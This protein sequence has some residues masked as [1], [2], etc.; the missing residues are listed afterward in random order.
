MKQVVFLYGLAACLLVC[1]SV[2]AQDRLVGGDDGQAFIDD[3]LDWE[4]FAGRPA[5][6]V[7]RCYCSFDCTS[8]DTECQEAEGDDLDLP[9]Q[10]SGSENGKP[11]VNPPGIVEIWRVALTSL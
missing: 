11:H 6:W 4:S 2:Y 9:G 3:G 10:C 5:S 7:C 8:Q 1:S